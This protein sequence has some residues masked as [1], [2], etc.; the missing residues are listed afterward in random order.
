MVMDLSFQIQELSV[1][2]TANE[3]R[4]KAVVSVV[5]SDV[6]YFRIQNPLKV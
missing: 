3:E 4:L 2:K 1:W 6:V 5:H